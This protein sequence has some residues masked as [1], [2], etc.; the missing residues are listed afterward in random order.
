M[1]SIT[2][3]FTRRHDPPASLKQ[4]KLLNPL[5]VLFSLFPLILV[6]FTDLHAPYHCD[7]SNPTRTASN[8]YTMSLLPNYHHCIPFY[9]LPSP[10][11]NRWPQEQLAYQHILH[12]KTQHTPTV[13]K[14]GAHDHNHQASEPNSNNKCGTFHTNTTTSSKTHQQPQSHAKAADRGVLLPVITTTKKPRITPTFRDTQPGVTIRRNTPCTNQ[15]PNNSKRLRPHP[16]ATRTSN[17]K[18]TRK[19]TYHSKSQAPGERRSGTEA[20]LCNTL[21]HQ[22]KGDSKA[23]TCNNKHGRGKFPPPSP[24]AAFQTL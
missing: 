12:K 5:L 17:E 24:I 6:T 19:T 23:T 10:S 8:P 2:S 16:E 13:S 15:R 22:Q 1:K 11:L 18:S 4:A 9:D 14:P 20:R 3:T 7:R 21:Q